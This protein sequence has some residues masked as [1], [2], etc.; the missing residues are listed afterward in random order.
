MKISIITATF[1]SAKTIESSIQSV[2]DQTYPD[3][4][5]IIVDGGSTD[6]TLELVESYQ[7][8]YTNIIFNSEPD[9]GIYD[10]LNKGIAKATGEVIGFLH[11]DDFFE[12]EKV[13]Q[14]IMTCFQNQQSDGVYGDLKY[15]NAA[16][17]TKVVRY[18]KSRSFHKSLLTKGWM[19]AHPT[20]F[21]KKEIYQ[22]FGKFDLK[23]SI[24]ADYDFMLRILKEEIL[25]FAYL[26][27]VITNMRVG[28]ASNRSLK[29]IIQKSKEDYQALQNNKIGGWSI[30]L[31]KNLSKIPQFFKKR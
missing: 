24:A 8:D 27:Q 31:Q 2:I 11:S 28:G 30:L 15:V 20:L 21:L 1:N 29:N 9:Q 10:A 5:Y 4:E 3:I 17:P 13:I 26:P 25:S 18:W 14:D 12:N 22:L 16:Q 7:K 23:F 19:P 6:Q